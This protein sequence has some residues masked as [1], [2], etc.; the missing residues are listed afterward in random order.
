MLR[1]PDNFIGGVSKRLIVAKFFEIFT[2]RLICLS[3]HFGYRNDVLYKFC[4]VVQSKKIFLVN[5]C[6]SYANQ[7]DQSKY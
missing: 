5:L 6:Y 3:K 1:R 4:F 2:E 7:N